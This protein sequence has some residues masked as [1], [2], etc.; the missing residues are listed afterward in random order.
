MKGE[1]EQGGRAI[2][3]KREKRE[4]YRWRDTGREREEGELLSLTPY[5]LTAL[6]LSHSQLNQTITR[7]ALF[8]QP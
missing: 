5:Q 6:Y 3:G 7:V 1:R 2:E 4:R 8:T